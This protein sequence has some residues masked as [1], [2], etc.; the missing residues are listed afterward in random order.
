MNNPTTNDGGPAFPV[1]PY[2]STS[3]Q[4]S[5]GSE[6]MTLRDYFAGQALTGLLANSGGNRGWGTKNW[7]VESYCFADAMLKA[8]EKSR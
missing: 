7:A 2:S 8:R 4:W 6:G 3:T 1:Q 5:D